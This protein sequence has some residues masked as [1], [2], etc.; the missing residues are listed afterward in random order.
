ME[1]SKGP[2]GLFPGS[3]G[4]LQVASYGTSAKFCGAERAAVAGDVSTGGC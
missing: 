4:S 2:P 1:E 3:I